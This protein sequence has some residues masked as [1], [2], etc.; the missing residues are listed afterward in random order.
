MVEE[1]ARVV[2]S[3]SPIRSSATSTSHPATSATYIGTG[4]TSA[5]TATAEDPLDSSATRLNTGIVSSLKDQFA[6]HTRS[7]KDAF[8]TTT[9][10]S[11]SAAIR[12]EAGDSL[13]VGSK[14]TTAGAAT[15]EVADSLDT[16]GPQ[17]ERDTSHTTSSLP[18]SANYAAELAFDAKKTV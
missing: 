12:T 8:D 6:A 14:P 13:P 15:T 9:N 5:A 7:P 11:P 16:A 1:G 18:V 4:N 3:D 2:D 10:S 17:V